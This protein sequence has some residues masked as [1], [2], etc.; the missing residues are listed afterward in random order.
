MTVMTNFWTK[1]FD[2]DEP[3][4]LAEFTL[5]FLIY[6]SILSAHYLVKTPAILHLFLAGATLIMA[7]PYAMLLIRRYR[8]ITIPKWFATAYAIF[9][10]TVWLI[11]LFVSG[12][13][14]LNI[15]LG[16]LAFTFP[17]FYPQPHRSQK[18]SE[19]SRASDV[20]H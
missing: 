7:F 6:S 4:G 19:T 5:Y 11:I 20:H 14:L 3:A 8:S 2:R 9:L 1:M 18:T 13:D 16:L 15:P 12:H 10:I 17:G